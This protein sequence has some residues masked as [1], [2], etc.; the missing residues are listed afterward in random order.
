MLEDFAVKK[1]NWKSKIENVGEI[2]AELNIL[3]ESVVFIDD[4]PRER[5]A[6]K[7]AFPDVRT[8]GSNP[9]LLRQI[10]LWSP[11]T[12][13]TFI[14]EESKNRTQ[15]IQAKI[16]VESIKSKMS[17]EDFLNKIKLKASI[18]E[19]KGVDDPRFNRCFELLNKTNQFNTTGKRWSL[20]EI[21]KKLGG[22]F[23]IYSFDAQDI[24]SSYGLVGALVFEKENLNQMVM[25][26]RVVGLGLELA[27][28][29]AVLNSL[30]VKGIQNVSAITIQTEANLLSRNVYE[31]FG[32][33]K[34]NDQ[35]WG[36]SLNN[37]PTP[38]SHITI[39]HVD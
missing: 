17:T 31:K 19:I 14:T 10:L 29:S 37:I 8:L 28:L 16:A 39:S 30:K 20:D 11:E 21:V 24:Y 1:I 26:C 12:Q 35:Y 3:P 34:I 25:S 5:D 33:T 23:H 9:Y 2:L 6:I 4:N 38:P 7:D 36:L 27:A 15:M 18:F 22:D 13:V 32:F